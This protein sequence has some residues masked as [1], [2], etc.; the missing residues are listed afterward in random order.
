MALTASNTWNCGGQRKLLI[1][2]WL[3][4][5]I[6]YYVYDV[7]LIKCL[8]NTIWLIMS[9]CVHIKSI[10]IHV[11]YIS[12]EIYLYIIYKHIHPNTQ[13][14]KK[15]DINAF[16]H[17]QVDKMRFLLS[18]GT[19]VQSILAF[20]ALLIIQKPRYIGEPMLTLNLGRLSQSG[21]I[22]KPTHCD[23]LNTFDRSHKCPQL[24]S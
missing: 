11:Y 22:R 21:V 9:V 15:I 8:C 2:L 4:E 24:S 20:D 10:S 5:Y 6:W 19:P 17:L 23:A 1:T 7:Y 12:I 18:A 13:I 14:Y 16:I 3:S